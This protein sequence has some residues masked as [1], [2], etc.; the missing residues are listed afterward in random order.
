MSNAATSSRIE[1]I[2]RSCC[3][4]QWLGVHRSEPS[5]MPY[6]YCDVVFMRSDVF[7]KLLSSTSAYFSCYNLLNA[8]VHK[9]QIRDEMKAAK[10]FKENGA[11]R[12]R[13][14]LLHSP[15]PSVQCNRRDKGH[16]LGGVRIR[17]LTTDLGKSCGHLD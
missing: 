15:L 9:S 1:G 8:F 4:C 3:C 5:I 14:S 7:L 13:I 17:R 2:S 16:R 12:T 6:L 10:F 11:S